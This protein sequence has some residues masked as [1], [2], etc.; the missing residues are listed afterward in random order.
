MNPPHKRLPTIRHIWCVECHLLHISNINGLLK[1]GVWKSDGI[2]LWKGLTANKCFSLGYGIYEIDN[3]RNISTD[4]IIINIIIKTIIIII[5]LIMLGYINLCLKCPGSIVS[6]NGL[7]C[8]AQFTMWE[9][10]IPLH[11]HWEPCIC[12]ILGIYQIRPLAFDIQTQLER[13]V[14]FMISAKII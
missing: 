5:L 12:N 14:L 11:L 3:S 9:V 1:K 10:F 6:M 13:F 2:G 4:I 8:V 7:K